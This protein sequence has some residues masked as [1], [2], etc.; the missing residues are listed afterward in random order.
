MKDNEIKCAIEDAWKEFERT[1]EIVNGASNLLSAVTVLQGI[2]DNIDLERAFGDG[3][4]EGFIHAQ[5]INDQ[6][7]ELLEDYKLKDIL[8]LSEQAESKSKYPATKAL[9]LQNNSNK[10]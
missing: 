3:Y 2:V 10:V 6:E 7:G 4:Y 9:E 1:G 5:K 8:N